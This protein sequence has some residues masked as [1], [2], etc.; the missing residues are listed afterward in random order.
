[1]SS[2]SNNNNDS[3]TKPTASGRGGGGGSHGGGGQGSGGG[4]HGGR[5]STRN[6]N[7]NNDSNSDHWTKGATEELGH[8]VF[9]CTLYKN[10]KACAET[11]KKIAVYVGK[12]YGQ[13]ADMMKHIV[14]HEKEP[15]LE[16]PN[17]LTTTEQKDQLKMFKWKEVVRRHMDKLESLESGK[18]KSHT[19]IW[20]QCSDVMKNEPES[21]EKC[22]ETNRKQ[23][24]ILLSKNIESLTHDF[25]DQKHLSGSMWHAHKSF[26]DAIQREDEDLKMFCD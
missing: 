25:Q 15:E 1:M 14:K 26:Y 5:G 22:E 13:N 7:K 21:L 8:N 3:M 23:N 10:I 12:E 17:D 24:Q 19:S 20:G 18:K 16:E 11:I 2:S 9:D 6:C 4:S